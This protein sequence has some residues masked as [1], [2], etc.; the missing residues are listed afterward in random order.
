MSRRTPAN[1]LRSN[2]QPLV[3]AT[4]LISALVPLAAR[5]SVTEAAAGC[6]PV[7]TL[8][9]FC[10]PGL[11]PA[12]TYVTRNF[13]PGLRVAVPAGGWRGGEDSS[14]E[15]RL[16]PPGQRGE[17][18][19]FW[20]DPHASTP[21]SER[22][23]PV[24]TSTPARVVRW[25]RSNK[26]L[27]VSAP[28]RT[29]IAGGL[30][31]TSVDLDDSPSAPRCDPTCPPGPCIGYFLFAGDGYSEAYGTGARSPVRL[32]F[33][34]I[35]PP[36]HVFTVGIESSSPKDFPRLIAEAAPIIAHVRLPVRLPAERR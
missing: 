24:D 8:A 35:G 11:L 9:H 32:Y 1:R 6:T 23:L 4:L 31:A 26:N 12:G 14:L 15:L 19:R 29:T 3:A 10:R 25:L 22:L 13:M 2:Q 33:A 17:Y 28:Q 18:V 7:K 5:A 16:E 20:L 36:A 34:R 21:C 30:A 27:T